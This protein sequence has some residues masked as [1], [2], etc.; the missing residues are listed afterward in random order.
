MQQSNQMDADQRIALLQSTRAHLVKQK[1]QLEN[2]IA[3]VREKA[4]KREEAK[5]G[6]EEKRRELGM[7]R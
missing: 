5:R 3:E 4:N 1:E 7:G 2:K 6:R